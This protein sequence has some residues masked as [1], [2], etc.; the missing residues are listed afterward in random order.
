MRDSERATVSAPS[1]APHLHLS[2]TSP[3]SP[4]PP[5]SSHR[6]ADRGGIT[7]T[8][9]AESTVSAVQAA[10]RRHQT[11]IHEL[12][13]KLQGNREQLVASRKQCDSADIS[14]ANLERKVQD[15]QAH[16][17]LAKGQNNKTSQ[18][19]ELLQKSLDSLKADKGSLEK[20]RMEVNAMVSFI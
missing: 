19:R 10:L 14:I 3:P 5:P 13:V 7:G 20:N 8:A 1:P 11:Y 15:L 9:L 16:L 17:D 2:H 18:E 6:S 4:P 12:Q